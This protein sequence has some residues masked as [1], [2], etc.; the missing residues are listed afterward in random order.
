EG[1]EVKLFSA[2]RSVIDAFRHERLV[3]RNLAI[4]SLREALRQRKTTPGALAD[5]AMRVGAW[6]KVRPYLEALT[7]DA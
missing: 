3:G 5:T 6:N 2:A 7:A 1:V 4:E